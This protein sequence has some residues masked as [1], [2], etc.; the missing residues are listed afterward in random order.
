MKNGTVEIKK[1]SIVRET[2]KA[3]QIAVDA[4]CGS[5]V[6]ERTLKIWIPKSQCTINDETVNAKQWIFEKNLQEAAAYFRT[7]VIHVSNVSI[8]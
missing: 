4:I 2:E 1:N 7:N 6:A 8:A 5:G 3:I